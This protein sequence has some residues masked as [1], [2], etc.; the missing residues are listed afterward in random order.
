[1]RFVSGMSPLENLLNTMVFFNFLTCIGLLQDVDNE[2]E[3][4]EAGYVA[5]EENDH[6]V[7]IGHFKMHY[8]CIFV[9]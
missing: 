7:C 2:V 5:A 6:V 1:M 3:T 4:S 8:C 9:N